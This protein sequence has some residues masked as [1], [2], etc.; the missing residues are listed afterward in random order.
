MGRSL[1]STLMAPIVGCNGEI[2]VSLLSLG[3]PHSLEECK[4]SLRLRGA[5]PI[6]H[7]RFRDPVLSEAQ[8]ERFH[9]E[10]QDPVEEENR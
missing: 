5:L 2:K 3:I 6:P 7:R 1:K 4:Q 8:E 9:R 10:D